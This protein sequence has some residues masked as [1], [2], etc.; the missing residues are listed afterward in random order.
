MSLG[1]DMSSYLASQRS[2]AYS[3][4]SLASSIQAN[5]GDNNSNLASILGSIT[6]TMT[7]PGQSIAGSSNGMGN[8]GSGSGSGG[9]AAA[10][11]ATSSKAGTG[12]MGGSK[13]VP[14]VVMHSIP[15]LPHFPLLMPEWL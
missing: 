1:P 6:A 11:T 12:A 8:A 14:G 10:A 13:Q 3:Y 7:G 4:L 9:A 2:E 15:S 5:G